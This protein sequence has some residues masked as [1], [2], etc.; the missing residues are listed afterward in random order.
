MDLLLP[1]LLMWLVTLQLF[2]PEP[3]CLV[4][5]LTWLSGWVWGAAGP[6]WPQSQPEG[7]PCILWPCHEKRLPIW[8]ACRPSAALFWHCLMVGQQPTCWREHRSHR[9]CPRACASCRQVLSPWIHPRAQG[10]GL[11]FFPPHPSSKKGTTGWAWGH[12]SSRD[13]K[14]KGQESL[15]MWV[16]T[17]FTKAWLSDSY[18]RAGDNQSKET[19]DIEILE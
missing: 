9:R 13:E 4:I 10:H 14:A 1:A 5:T 6:A 3:F 16:I 11:S 8:A 18:L 15:N 19:L 12:C 7:C 17:G 2:K